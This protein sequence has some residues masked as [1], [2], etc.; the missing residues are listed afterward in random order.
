MCL[1][2][3]CL[4]FIHLKYRPLPQLSTLTP[5]LQV[6][7]CRW[8]AQSLHGLSFW[9][10][11]QNCSS[12]HGHLHRIPDLQNQNIMIICSTWDK[13]IIIVGIVQ[14]HEDTVHP[15]KSWFKATRRNSGRSHSDRY[16][17]AY[18]EH[19]NY[20]GQYNWLN[21]STYIQ[22]FV[23]LKQLPFI[24]PQ[25][26]LLCQQ[27]LKEVGR[28]V[29]CCTAIPAWCLRCFSQKCWSSERQ[30]N[31]KTCLSQATAP[32]MCSPKT[33]WSCDS[34]LCTNSIVALCFQGT[35]STVNIWCT[36]INVHVHH[37]TCSF[38]SKWIIT[39]WAQCFLI[40]LLKAL[41]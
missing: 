39:V 15:P 2:I 26:D 24:S 31:C 6:L 7:T 11:E 35:I 21:V 29:Q 4:G 14:R 9:A 16:T 5:V 20:S 18:T 32:S 13:A 37:P 1:N 30:N 40:N 25:T 41:I 19:R 38:C 12:I 34:S 17:E 36:E 28:G 27:K 33:L 23:A 22:K 10:E 8:Y 3:E